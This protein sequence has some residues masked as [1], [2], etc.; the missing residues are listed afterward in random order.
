MTHEL[1]LDPAEPASRLA[2]PVP[3][4]AIPSRP[5]LRIAP[6]VVLEA[7]HTC[8]TLRGVRAIGAKT[9]TFTLLGAM[10]ADANSRA[11]FFALAG[12]PG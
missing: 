12:V 9:I 5:D 6:G 3:G 7:E 1:I 4:I 11:E 10:R 2:Q 8:M